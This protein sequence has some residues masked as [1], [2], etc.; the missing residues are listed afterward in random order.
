VA[1][2]TRRLQY[3][4]GYPE[5]DAESDRVVDMMKRRLQLQKPASALSRL[6]RQAVHSRPHR[7]RASTRPDRRIA[8][9]IAAD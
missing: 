3:G 5:A 6:L 2:R 8:A 7:L 1:F 9:K 4:A